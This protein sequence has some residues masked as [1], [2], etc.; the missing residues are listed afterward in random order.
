[1]EKGLLAKRVYVYKKNVYVYTNYYNIYFFIIILLL[2]YIFH[3]TLS[4]T[5]DPI[6]KKFWELKQTMKNKK[7]VSARINEYAYTKLQQNTTTISKSQY[8][9]QAILHYNNKEQ[10]NNEI[11]IINAKIQQNNE[12]IKTIAKTQQQLK[13]QQKTL[14]KQLKQDTINPH[15]YIHAKKTLQNIKERTG[16]ITQNQYQI[17][18]NKLG[19]PIT[20][21]KQLLKEDKQTQ[22]RQETQ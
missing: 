10:Q 15:Q 13:T 1:M 7:A 21:L 12:I 5:Y 2:Y 16:T 11:N 8:I 6:Q 20:Q 9:E 14:Q 17:Q 19:I 4:F 18:A 22:R 3:F